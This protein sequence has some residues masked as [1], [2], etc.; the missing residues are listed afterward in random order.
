MK[1]GAFE[2]QDPLPEMHSPHALAI[3]RPWLDAGLAGRTMLTMLEKIFK[4]EKLGKLVRPGN[5]FDFTRYR[6]IMSI[7]DGERQVTIPNSYINYA[8]RPDSNELVFMQL[9]EP[10]F[11]SE[12][13]IESTVKILQVL[14]IKR[15]CLFGSMYDTVPHTRPLSVSGIGDRVL[16]EKLSHLGVRESKYE[17]PTSIAF[18]INQEAHR[19]G[20]EMIT[21]IV[22]LPQ[23]AQFEEDYSGQLRLME[24]ACALYDFPIDLTPLR[25]RAERQYRELD[26]NMEN[27]PNILK[28]VKYFESVYDSRKN[29]TDESSMKLS[30]DVENFLREIDK[31]FR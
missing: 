3:L 4:A 13:Y 30:P 5:F 26:Y 18:L 27:D 20:M 7:A 28:V 10:H 9:L 22:H 16:L 25:R 17:G 23:Y 12:I 11:F 15:F 2:L 1:I 29:K 14:G 24:L 6:P 31:N 21:L 8:G 19:L